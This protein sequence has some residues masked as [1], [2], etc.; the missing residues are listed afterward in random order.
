MMAISKP[1]TIQTKQQKENYDRQYE[2]I[3]GKI[4]NESIKDKARKL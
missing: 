1:T 3:F 2:K 4:K